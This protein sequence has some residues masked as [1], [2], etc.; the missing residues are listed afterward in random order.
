MTL[1]IVQEDEQGPPPLDQR[2]LRALEDFRC[3]SLWCWGSWCPRAIHECMPSSPHPWPSLRPLIA[4]AYPTVHSCLSPPPHPSCL[5]VTCCRSSVS[6]AARV[7]TENLSGP[8]LTYDNLATEAQM[9]EYDFVLVS[10]CMID[11]SGHSRAQ[12]RRAAAS[13]ISADLSASGHTRRSTA[14]SGSADYGAITGDDNRP[15]T[16]KHGGGSKKVSGTQDPLWP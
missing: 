2:L 13:A 4:H 16:P 9:K 8:D 14:A 1:L 5:H 15:T 11:A 7:T 10:H 3:A 6:D 12:Q